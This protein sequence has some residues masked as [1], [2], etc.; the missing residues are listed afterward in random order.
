MEVGL[1]VQP[2]DIHIMEKERI[3]DV[4]EGRMIYETHV[5]FFV[6]EFDCA[7]A[8]IESGLLNWN[9]VFV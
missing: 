5:V 3:C 9:H 1:R 8:D 7:R 4:F 2:F 6:R